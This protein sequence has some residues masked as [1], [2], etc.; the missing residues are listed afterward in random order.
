MDHDGLKLGHD[1]AMYQFSRLAAT[2]V[3][4]TT[5]LIHD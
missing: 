2:T 1:A 4:D 5:I 3:T